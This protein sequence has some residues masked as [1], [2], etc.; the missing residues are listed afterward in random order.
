MT[1]QQ[2]PPTAG[3]V[4]PDG[5]YVWDGS[6]WAPNP[7]LPKPPAPKKGHMARNLGVG[8][9][10]LIILVVIIVV[11]SGGSK[12]TT[13]STPAVADKSPSAKPAAAPKVLLDVTGSG[14]KQTQKFT[15]GGDWDLEWSYDCASFGT[16]GNFVVTA[17]G[18]DGLPAVLT[19]ELGAKGADV[20]HQHNAGTFYLSV[21]SECS[22]HV[23]V[24]G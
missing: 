2:P 10:G 21:N 1:E 15:A 23:V 16:S 22:W 17:Y 18:S 14:I 13:T 8:C 19:N 9:L 6:Q 5:Q 20:T 4:S 7:N 12:S 3:A 11:A 24:K